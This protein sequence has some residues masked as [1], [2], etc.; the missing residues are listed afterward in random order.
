VVGEGA[1]ELPAGLGG[2]CG[3]RGSCGIFLGAQA[4]GDTKSG[5]SRVGLVSGGSSGVGGLGER[6]SFCVYE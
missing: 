5:G 4:L 1:G 3:A 6:M 2:R